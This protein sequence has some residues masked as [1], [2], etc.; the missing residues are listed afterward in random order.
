MWAICTAD[1][2]PIGCASACA[3][4]TSLKNTKPLEQSNGHVAVT[5]QPGRVAVTGDPGARLGRKEERHDG[6]LD[7]R[8]FG[9]DKCE[10]RRRAHQVR[11]D[12]L[13]NS[14]VRERGALERQ[15]RNR[16]HAHAW[17]Q[18]WCLQDSVAVLRTTCPNLSPMAQTSP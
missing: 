15:W 18:F 10:R 6:N 14:F 4:A 13:R 1:S 7:W 12:L 2:L 5:Q 3:L 9:R 11:G 16:K 8:Q 17:R